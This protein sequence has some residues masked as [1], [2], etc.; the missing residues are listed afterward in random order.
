MSEPLAYVASVAQDFRLAVRSLRKSPGFL[1]VVTLSLALGIGANSTVFSVIDTLLY[2]PLPYDHPE[3]L[4][5]IW[6]TNAGEGVDR[7]PIAES[8]DWKRQN[9]VF[10]DIALTSFDEE[11]VLS[12]AGAPEH[13]TVQDVTPNFFSL[14]GAK[15]FLGRIFFPSEMQDHDQTIV[16][17]YSL[18]KT[19]FN[20]NPNVLGKTLNLSGMPSTVVGVMP[21]GFAPFDG[22]TMIWQPVNPESQRY[23]DRSDHWLIPIARL[24]PS[25]TQV[26]AQAEMD[27]IAH[28]LEQQYPTSNKGVGKKLVPLRETSYGW[29]RRALYPLFG[30]VAFVLLIACANVANLIQSRSERRRGESA[31]RLS[32]GATRARLVQQSLVESM[33]LGLLGCAFGL[34]IAYWGIRIFLWIAGADFPNANS[35]TVNLRVV[36]FTAGISLLTTLL[37]GIAPALQASK[38]DL[39]NALRDGARG[40]APS[41]RGIMRHFLVVSEVALAMV[42][43]VGTGLMINTMLRLRHVNPGFDTKNLLTMTFQLPEGGKY[44]ER[45]PGGDMEK[46]TP[47]VTSFYQ[48]LLERVSALPGVES[49]A[50][51]TGLPTHFMEWPSFVILGRPVPTPDQR[52]NAGCAQVSPNIFRTL[53]IQLK[54]G[55]FLDEHDNSA[56]P[57]AVV[58]NQ[59]FVRRYFPNED[60]IG[61]EIRLRYDPYPTEEG[62]PRQIV[63]VV[64]DIKQRGLA[65]EPIPFMYTSFL[66]EP[67]VYPGGSIVAH[68]WQDLAVRMAPGTRVSDLTKAIRQI[69]T[70]L[71][72]DQPIANVMSMDQLLR[73]DLGDTRSYMQ[74]LSIFAVVAVFLAGMGIYSVMSY[75]VTRHTHDIGIRMA[76][77]AHPSNILRWVATLA[78]KL[79]LMGIVVGIG[80]ALGLTRAISALL[81]GVTPTDPTT[82]LIVAI[83][84]ALVA[85]VACYIPARRATKLDPLVSLRYE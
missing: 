35:M 32:L 69:V 6:N 76:L 49:A 11:A 61:K 62:R 51:M 39:N 31:V 79:V 18:W 59:A 74:L 19:H 7:A 75:F 83:T 70:E 16:I 64:G 28:R 38:T 40:T 46:A 30:A 2:R 54:K 27:A 68:L 23:A 44:V 72:P 22:V 20:K 3:Q 33:P 63:G 36:V 50:S 55:R 66:Q 26:Q 43:L 4:I 85:C 73:Q 15:P 10:Q 52:P 45:V 78:A 47:A 82:F 53:G 80:L 8:L 34:L 56:A 81:F 77:G 71:E 1:T 42:L 48:R 21:E 24:K 84:L 57:W 37:F 25:V 9:H 17:S 65:R 67:E 60:P 5:T 58:V 14:L 12:G 41:A 13:V 29:A